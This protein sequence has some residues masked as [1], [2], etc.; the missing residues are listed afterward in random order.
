MAAT[1]LLLYSSPQYGASVYLNYDDVTLAATGVTLSCG[2]VARPLIFHYALAGVITSLQCTNGH[3]VKTYT[4]P[5]PLQGQ[6]VTGPHGQTVIDFGVHRYG[7]GHGTV[8]PSAV[9]IL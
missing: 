3:A 6:L 4:F 8:P 1:T 7:A 9:T 2:L 5:R